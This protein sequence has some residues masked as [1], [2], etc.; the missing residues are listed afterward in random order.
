MKQ[1]NKERGRKRK[2]EVGREE[3]GGEGADTEADKRQA[4]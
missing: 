2:G 3:E 1:T 4:V